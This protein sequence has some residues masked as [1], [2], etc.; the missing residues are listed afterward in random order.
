MIQLSGAEALGTAP[1]ITPCVEWF[2]SAGRPRPCFFFAFLTRYSVD[3]RSLT[4]K[5][6][7]RTTPSGVHEEKKQK[8]ET[9]SIPSPIHCLIFHSELCSEMWR[10]SF[11][12]G[13]YPRT[14]DP[15][16]CPHGSPQRAG[17]RRRDACCG[18]NI[19]ELWERRL[20]ARNWPKMRT[21]P[22]N[23]NRKS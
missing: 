5:K 9:R 20:F 8:I 23:G 12:L 11:S 21:A 1:S 15:F 13:A 19:N 10:A 3:H 4:K 16:Y 18:E 7:V 17:P 22:A 14:L 6:K 2:A